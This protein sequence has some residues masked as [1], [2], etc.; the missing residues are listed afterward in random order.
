MMSTE[1][2]NGDKIKV[3]NDKTA[4]ALPRWKQWL[5]LAITLLL[6][7]LLVAVVEILLRLFG[8]GGDPPFITEIGET[9]TGQKLC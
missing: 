3:M 6:P 5:F 9:A 4:A 8:W 1:A 2:A 7:V